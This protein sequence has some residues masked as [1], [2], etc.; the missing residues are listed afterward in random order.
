MHV[1]AHPCLKQTGFNQETVCTGVFV[2]VCG[3]VHVCVHACEH[4]CM[5][6]PLPEILSVSLKSSVW[7][8]RFTCLIHFLVTEKILK[9]QKKETS[10]TVKWELTW[11]PGVWGPGPSGVW[12]SPWPERRCAP[13]S[14]GSPGL[15]SESACGTHSQRCAGGHLPVSLHI[16]SLP[17]RN[18]HNLHCQHTDNSFCGWQVLCL[19]LLTKVDTNTD[20]HSGTNASA[21]DVHLNFHTSPELCRT[22]RQVLRLTLCYKK[23]WAPTSNLKENAFISLSPTSHISI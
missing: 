12:C 16:P 19:T 17:V 14:A 1:C 6:S 3:C 4:A 23:I 10:L 9:I 18:K 11:P 8:G 20:V 13:G 22:G 21:Q 5:C 7:V 15:E 2:W